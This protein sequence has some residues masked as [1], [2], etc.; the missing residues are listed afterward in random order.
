MAVPRV[1][2]GLHPITR[3]P[4]HVTGSAVRLWRAGR[5]RQRQRTRTV[6]RQRHAIGRH[7][8][9]LCVGEEN[10]RPPRRWRHLLVAGVTGSKI[11]IHFL[12]E[13][14]SLYLLNHRIFIE[15][16]KIK[17]LNMNFNRNYVYAD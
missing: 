3:S 5:Q 10:D 2:Q 17:Y 9:V 13:Y 1:R 6:V 4:S 8:V 15:A 11:Y 7:R 12:L 16:A 14:Y